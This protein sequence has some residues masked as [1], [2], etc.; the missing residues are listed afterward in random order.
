ML[1]ICQA[2]ISEFY[3]NYL[4]Q[5]STVITIPIPVHRSKTQC[6]TAV[7]LPKLT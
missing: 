5:D 3:V 4:K 2:L 6:Y 1:I 7:T